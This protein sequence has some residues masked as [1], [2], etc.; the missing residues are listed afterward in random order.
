[1]E[2][3]LRAWHRHIQWAFALLSSI[4]QLV[5]QIADEILGNDLRFEP[6][7]FLGLQKR[8]VKTYQK[9]I[10]DFLKWLADNRREPRRAEEF[11]DCLFAYFQ[12]PDTGTWR[13]SRSKAEHLVAAI[14]RVLPR[15]K[16][17][18]SYTRQLLRDWSKHSPSQHTTPEPWHVAL[19]IGQWF[20][21]QG[22]ARLGALHVLQSCTGLRPS[23]LLNLKQSDLR[24]YWLNAGHGQARKSLISLGIR[25][26]TKLGRK[27]W[28][29]VDADEDSI[30]T[31]LITIFYLCTKAGGW[32]WSVRTVGEYNKLLHWA[33]RSLNLQGLGITGHAARAGWATRLRSSG[34]AFEEVRERGRWTHDKSL[35]TY[36]DVVGAANLEVE[37]AHV[38]PTASWLQ[39]DFRG[40]FCWWPG[41]PPPEGERYAGCGR[42]PGPVMRTLPL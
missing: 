17:R 18:L 4:W 27:Q 39:E 6:L 36:L 8:T 32:L 33:A 30:G 7:L 13:I 42:V 26:T 11:D 34:L 25:R 19:A 37:T 5:R 35:R 1:M 10:K 12:N 29:T 40:R 20:G 14:E 15:F 22:M 2:C 28:V 21:L 3:G 23:E 24:P 41:A 16:G 31:L 38:R 9:E